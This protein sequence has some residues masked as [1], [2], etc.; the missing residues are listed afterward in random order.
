MKNLYFI[1]IFSFCT[2]FHFAQKSDTLSFLR[3][4]TVLIYDNP[5]LAIQNGLEVINNSENIEYKIQAYK[6]IS[7]AYSSKRDYQKAL[8]YVIKAN[9]LLSKT[10]NELLKIKLIVKTG[11]LY[12]QLKIYD[13]ALQYLDDGEQLAMRYPIQDSIYPSLGITNA[14]RGFIY[15]E[16]FNCEIAINYFDK[17]LNALNKIANNNN[18]L[19]NISIVK[20][21]KGNCYLMSSDLEKAKLNFNEAIEQAISIN[22]KS[23]E[24]F[25]LKGLAQVYTVESK[26]ELALETLKKALLISSDVNDLILNQEIYKGFSNNYLAINN[27]EKFIEYHKRYLQTQK[28]IK[29]S[30]RNS[31]SNSINAKFK[32]KIE[33]LNKKINKFYITIITAIL[34]LIV[35][36]IAFVFS[37]KKQGI[38]NRKLENRLKN[39]QNEKV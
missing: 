18:T 28:Q 13:K 38:K 30:E 32:E 23:L 19:A 11:T 3:N 17:S 8:D 16:K 34:G 29:L 31:I 21:N 9:Q 2:T 36:V 4:S 14:V 26:Y 22:A 37:F 27:K 6:L 5:D 7:D 12:H 25:A 35:I 10:K 39:L 15:K 20:Y 1:I 24:A 33:V